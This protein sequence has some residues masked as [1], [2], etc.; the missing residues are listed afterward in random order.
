MVFD[1]LPFDFDLDGDRPL[2]LLSSLFLA[3]FLS[4]LPAGDLDFET[5]DFLSFLAAPPFLFGVFDFDLF[6]DTDLSLDC[7]LYFAGE[8]DFGIFENL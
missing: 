7:D 5:F 2:D 1:V 4:F 6:F 8:C 3:D